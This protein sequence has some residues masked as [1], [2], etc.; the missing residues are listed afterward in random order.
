[1]K[2]LILVALLLGFLSYGASGQTRRHCSKITPSTYRLVHETTNP[3]EFHRLVTQPQLALR[4]KRPFPWPSVNPNHNLKQSLDSM[5]S[6]VYDPI[7]QSW[8]Q[9]QKKEYSYNAQG[10]L[11][12]YKLAGWDETQGKW[13]PQ[14]KDF[15]QYDLQG[16]LLIL[17][18]C[19]WNPA[20]QTWVNNMREDYTYT[21]GNQ[22][23]EHVIYQWN[24]TANGWYAVIQHLFDYDAFGNILTYIYS[25]W[26]L[27]IHEWIGDFKEEFTYD[28]TGI[29]NEYRCYT[30][31]PPLHNWINYILGEYD[32]DASG[33]LITY[34]SFLRNALT[35]QMEEEF[36]H[37][38]QYDSQG[39]MTQD[40]FAAYDL[41]TQ[42]WI[43][44]SKDDFTYH[45]SGKTSMVKYA[46]WKY[47]TQWVDVWKE[48]FTFNAQDYQIAYDYFE[49]HETQGQWIHFHHRDRQTDGYGNLLKL[50]MSNYS[51]STTIWTG[52]V[53]ELYIYNYNYNLLSLILP[54]WIQDELVP[55]QHM[56][57][58]RT[59]LVWDNTLQVW[60]NAGRQLLYYAPLVPNGIAEDEHQ[61][62]V[63][64]W[65]NPTTGVVHF[66]LEPSSEP[67]LVELYNLT[68]ELVLQQELS[69]DN[70]LQISHLTGGV[71][72]Y[73]VHCKEGLS[74]GRLVVQ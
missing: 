17:V 52:D 32:Y 58:S 26:D 19:T 48:E 20:T 56:L 1:M 8:T 30:W 7:A 71:Y 50:E 11:V 9:S 69:G 21:A 41:N 44:D 2:K 47:G 70:T 28:S 27:S 46:E 60:Q 49:W 40:I 55:F 62:Q 42:Q 31:N 34:T 13:R 45:S 38:Y 57:T 14:E 73:K 67:A 29:V 66:T 22:V 35:N 64:P 51:P 10:K 72:L 5:I 37:D 59:F 33:N 4:Q 43:P 63:K 65:P 18:K 15:Y 12:E 74:Q 25:T 6:Q 36:K 68:G 61:I 24:T 16:N 53:Q 39:Q 23:A 54:P 3:Q